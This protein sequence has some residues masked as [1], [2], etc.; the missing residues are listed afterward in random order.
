MDYAAWKL[1]IDA[2]ELGS[3]SK[4]ALAYG[5]SQPVISRRIA[6]LEQQCGGRLFERTGRGVV[7]TEFGQR[8]APKVRAWMANTDELLNDVRAATATPIGKVRIGSLPSTS[9]PLM[10]ML[11]T[12]IR[13]LYP[14]IQLSV[15]EAQ[16]SQIEAWLDDGSVDFATVY[17]NS[18]KP[19]NG[20]T[21]L[22]E[23]PTYL[24]GAR[25][26]K[27]TKTPTVPFSALEKLPLVLF[28]RP[29]AW[30]NHLE[31]VAAERGIALSVVLE[32]DSLS[33][34]TRIASEGE[35]YALLSPYAI[36][37]AAEGRRLQ[38]ARVVSPSVTRYLA[39]SVS[40]HAQ[41]TLACRTVLQVAQEIGQSLGKSDLGRLRE[42]RKN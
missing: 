18:Q 38:A 41:M 39:L 13:Q 12:R 5:T 1:F 17:R 32:A 16:G 42:N 35:I 30:R 34:Q 33:I 9:H 22:A 19:L 15:R 28:C 6:E 20:E 2:G 11:H 8:I 25:G 31:Q 36:T 26:S 7:L 21:Y 29:S 40:R 3:L 4:V 10:S 14:Q 37:A 24:V 27:I 23:I